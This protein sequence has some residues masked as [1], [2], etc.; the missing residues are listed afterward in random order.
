MPP[1]ELLLRYLDLH[2]GEGKFGCD[3]LENEKP[4]AEAC[5][6]PLKSSRKRTGWV[7]P[8]KAAIGGC[9]RPLMITW[10]A[11][12]DRCA[13]CVLAESQSVSVRHVAFGSPRLDLAPVRPPPAASDEGAVSFDHVGFGDSEVLEER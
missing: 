3:G 12:I 5:M 2:P 11:V 9:N 7:L 4:T 6:R 13:G 8:A 1:L 10:R